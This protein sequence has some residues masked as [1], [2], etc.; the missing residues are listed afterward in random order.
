MLLTPDCNAESEHYR[1]A[2]SSVSVISLTQV[3]TLCP[4][5]LTNSN[6]LL[7]TTLA[8]RVAPITSWPTASMTRAVRV[9]G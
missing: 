7:A 5:P 6:S 4:V 8:G 3:Y 2:L 1:T 9:G